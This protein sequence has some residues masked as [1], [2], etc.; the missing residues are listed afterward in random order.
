MAG[1]VL[2]ALGLLSAVLTLN[3][4]RPLGAPTLPAMASS[5]LGWT[6]GEFALHHIGLQLAL[7]LVFAASG[8]FGEAAGK[9]GLVPQSIA[10]YPTLTAEENLHFFG[11]I[12]SS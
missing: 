2:L 6:V 1:E 3:V 5:F 12:Q 11:R 7:T 10:L 8:G 9:L 4:Y